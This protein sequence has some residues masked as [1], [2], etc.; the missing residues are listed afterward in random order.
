MVKHTVE[1]F[2]RALER[3]IHNS[4][5][6]EQ[7]SITEATLIAVNL[8]IVAVD[9]DAKIELVNHE[10][11]ALLDIKGTLVVGKTFDEVI[12]INNE[13]YNMRVESFIK[14][15]IMTQHYL[16]FTDPLC[17]IIGDKSI[18]VVCRIS[19]KYDSKKNYRG[20]V[21]IFEK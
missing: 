9:E 12:N 17:L 3:K 21:V 11:E 15:M 8:G 16:P 19:P 5:L 4:L 7:A 6:F 2:N 18:P 13:T 20:A 10:A 14:D 1:I